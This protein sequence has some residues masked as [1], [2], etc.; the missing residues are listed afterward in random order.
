M[1][2]HNL[3]QKVSI[4]INIVHAPYLENSIRAL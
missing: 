1:D 2:K 3:L 4:R